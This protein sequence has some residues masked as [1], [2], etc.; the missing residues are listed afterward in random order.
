MD[1]TIHRMVHLSH[2]GDQRTASALNAGR[3]VRAVA[4]P[5]HSERGDAAF[6]SVPRFACCIAS[7]V[8]LFAID[9]FVF[10]VRK[11]AS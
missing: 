4:S 11:V 7:G 2:L 10:P 8:T 6:G 9:V 1:P 3:G 5:L